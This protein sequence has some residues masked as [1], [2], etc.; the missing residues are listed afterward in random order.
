MLI[1]D[2]SECFWEDCCNSP[3]TVCPTWPRGIVGSGAA[4][5]SWPRETQIGIRLECQCFVLSIYFL[6]F[7]HPYAPCMVY[8]PT[9]GWFLG[10]ML[11][12]IPYME[13]MGQFI[14]PN[15]M[16]IHRFKLCNMLEMISRFRSITYVCM[17]VRAHYSFL[18][19]CC[20]C[21]LK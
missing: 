9:F 3:G 10:H 1:S 14:D 19:C 11:A 13:H 8:L 2:H 18:E 12:N 16:N 21:W 6:G 20:V 15:H 7:T 17:L 4:G 5:L